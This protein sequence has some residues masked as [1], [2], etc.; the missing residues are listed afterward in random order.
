VAVKLRLKRL[1]KK[2][3]PVYRVVAAESKNPRDG[4]TLETL[5]VYN[6]LKDPVEISIKKERVTYWLSVGAQPTETLERLLSQE[7]LLPEKKRHS[8][9]QKISKKDRKEKES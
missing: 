2:K 6:P 3:Q 5:G 7:G 4:R 9:N 8:S 1:G